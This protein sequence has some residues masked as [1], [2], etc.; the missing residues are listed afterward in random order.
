MI[1][2]FNF[3]Q[4]AF[5]GFKFAPFYYATTRNLKCHNETE[6]GIEPWPC[7]YK[8]SCNNDNS[9]N[10]VTL[11]STTSNNYYSKYFKQKVIH[12]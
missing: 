5:K 10:S 2:D 11:E 9:V 8:R 3:F 4:S 1:R 12:F 6:V 7:D